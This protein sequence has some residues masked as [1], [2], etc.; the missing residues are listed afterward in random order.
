MEK[1]WHGSHLHCDKCFRQGFLERGYRMKEEKSARDRQRRQGQQWGLRGMIRKV[2]CDDEDQGRRYLPED[3]VRYCRQVR[4][5]TKKQFP[6]Y[7]NKS[8]LV[9]L[10][11]ETAWVEALVF[12]CQAQRNKCGR[13]SRGPRGSQIRM[14]SKYMVNVKKICKRHMHCHESPSKSPHFQGRMYFMGRWH[15]LPTLQMQY[16]PQNRSFLEWEK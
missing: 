10:V 6:G 9:T 5:D 7:V 13:K 1:Y 12:R 4:T 3:R 14:W 16:I 8:S 2:E 15:F 11:R